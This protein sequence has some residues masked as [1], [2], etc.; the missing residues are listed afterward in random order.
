MIGKP[1]C[2]ISLNDGL[3]MKNTFTWIGHRIFSG[4]TVFAWACSIKSV[5]HASRENSGYIQQ[6]G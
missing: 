1:T 5:I 6:P 2:Y 4:V 3:I